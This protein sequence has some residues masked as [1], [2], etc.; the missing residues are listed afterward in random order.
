MKLFRKSRFMRVKKGDLINYLLYALGEIVLVVTG[1]LIAVS[2]N[3]NNERK[4]S[5]EE[6]KNILLVIK[7]DLNN[8]LNEI[9]TILKYYEVKQEFF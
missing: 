2:I 9:D 4:K 5:N 1:I 6:Y 7:N 8:D 3:N